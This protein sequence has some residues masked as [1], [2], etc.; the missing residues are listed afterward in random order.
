MARPPGSDRLV[1]LAHGELP[2]GVLGVTLGGVAPS[3]SPFAAK[4]FILELEDLTTGGAPIIRKATIGGVIRVNDNNFCTT[5]G[6]PF[7][8]NTTS[9]SEPEDNSNSLRVNSSVGGD[10]QASETPSYTSTESERLDTIAQGR[11]NR[12]LAPNLLASDAN[13]KPSTPLQ[14]LT[15]SRSRLGRKQRSICRC[16]YFRSM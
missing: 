14:L 4:Q 10:L 5:A 2:P 12:I 8:P 9:Q 13:S 16:L 3:L 11:D 1:A 15:Q 7:P 6:H